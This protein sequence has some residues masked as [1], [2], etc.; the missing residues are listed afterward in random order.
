MTVGR[1]ADARFRLDTGTA[2]MTLNNVL[3]LTLAGDGNVTRQA[4]LEETYEQATIHSVGGGVSF[5]TIYQNTAFETLAT[6]AASNPNLESEF[7]IICEPVPRS[8]QII[9]IS[10]PRASY[11]APADD[12]ITRPWSLMRRGIG[13]VGT[14][15]AAFN[16]R[17]GVVRAFGGSSGEIGFIVIESIASGITDIDFSGTDLAG[18][19]A[20][21]S[22]TGIFGPITKNNAASRNL[23]ITATGGSGN[24][25]GYILTAGRREVV[26]SG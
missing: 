9:P 6:L 15:V 24:V 7:A 26:P 1:T 12:A 10:W 23:S 22:R 3:G 18:V 13:W 11:D 14:S 16:A 17:S 8:W 25:R 21:I 19:P 5:T 20:N 2:L 4:Y